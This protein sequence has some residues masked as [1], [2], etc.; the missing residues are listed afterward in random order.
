M[1]K[2]GISSYSQKDF[3]NFRSGGFGNRVLVSYENAANPKL[4]DECP[5]LLNL[6]SLANEFYDN[7]TI[8]STVLGTIS[9]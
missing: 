6:L 7:G 4:W 9:I 2:S 1:S 3:V 8:I 5:I